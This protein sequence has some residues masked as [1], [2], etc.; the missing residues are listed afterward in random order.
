MPITSTPVHALPEC[1]SVWAQLD[2]KDLA[3]LLDFGS[4]IWDTYE[5]TLDEIVPAD[6]LPELESKGV[7]IQQNGEWRF[8]LPQ[9]LFFIQAVD[10]IDSLV[11]HSQPADELFQELA[12]LLR[13]ASEQPPNRFKERSALI[14]FIIARLVNT[15]SRVDV[16]EC[17]LAEETPRDILWQFHDPICDAVPVFDLDAESFVAVFRQ[18]AE[19]T[20]GDLAGGRIFS[21][22]EYLGLFRPGLALELVDLLTTV[23]DWETVGF[24]EKLMTGVAN[25]SADHFDSVVATCE[26]WLSCGNERLCRAAIYCSQNLILGSKLEPDWLLLRVAPLTPQ[27][28]E[29]MRFTLAV[30]ISN[31][32]VRFRERS[33]ECLSFLSQLKERESEGEVS[34]G[35]AIALA[36]KDEAPLEY[37]VSCLALLTDVPAANKGTIR[38]IG[39]FLY[40]VARSHPKEVWKYLEEW[41][42][43]HDYR[44]ASIVEHDMFLSRIQDAYQCDSNLGTIVLTRWFA[45]PDQ[46]VVEEARS[47]LRELRIPG[48]ASQEVASMPPHIVKY[49]TEKLLVGHFEG[50]HLLR[51]LYSILRNTSRV[52]ELEQ[53]FLEVLR[54]VT[55][56]YPGSAMEFFEHVISEEDTALPSTLLR[57]ARQE[58]KE[59]QAQRRDIFVPELAPSKRRVETFLEL[60]GKKMQAVQE[61]TFDDDRFPLQKLLPRVAI[62][63]GDRTF[64]MNI[65][66]PDP[67]QKRTFTEPRGFGHL[68][69]SIELPRA[70]II[71][72]EGEA[73][74]RFQRRSYTPD[75]FLEDE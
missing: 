73:W 47:V 23:G 52:E 31:L 44:E 42:L 38:R 63:R 26:S 22:V 66:H 45:S 50:T 8:A 27:S 32:G 55:W 17:V 37:R 39:W 49:I 11:L 40:P 3:I 5:S 13:V 4:R 35:I 2:S 34:H 18:M 46:R 12:E 51:L 25:S 6:R 71:D 19:R 62:G 41:I 60:E 65:F 67:A 28:T 68:S 33:G 14:A 7:L 24:L 30:A 16:L 29:N 59:Y 72:P 61:A 74:R 1:E 36:H 58:L 21:A 20:K 48:F 69:E 64:H 75:D 43:A 9:M 10:L 54:Y 56:N 57:K 53:Y 70:E 15:F